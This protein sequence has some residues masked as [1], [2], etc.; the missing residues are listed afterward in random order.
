M[1]ARYLGVVEVVGSHPATQ[2]KKEA[3]FGRQKLL[4]FLSIAKAM[5]YHRRQVYIITAGAYHQP[6]AVYSF[7]MM[8]YKTPF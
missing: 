3:T 5:A 7:T 2:T 1:V 4:L 6:Q 8:I